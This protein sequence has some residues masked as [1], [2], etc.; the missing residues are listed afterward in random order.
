MTEAAVRGPHCQS[1]A[2]V[3]DGKTRNGKERCR[4]SQSAQC[5]RTVLQSSSY[6]GCLP[7]VKQPIVEMTRNGRGIRDLVR[8]LQ[9]GPHTVLKE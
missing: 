3:R 7:P 4:G 5:G 8:G 9:V 6:P 1:D 2:V